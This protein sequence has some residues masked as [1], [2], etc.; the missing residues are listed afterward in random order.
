MVPR[1]AQ[2]SLRKGSLVPRGLWRAGRRGRAQCLA[3]ALAAAAGFHAHATVFVHR[4]V[5]RTLLGTDT[6]REG[7]QLDLLTDQ[8]GVRLLLPR[9]HPS[10]RRADVRAIEVET[11]A[12]CQCLRIGLAGARIRAGGAD[13]AQAKHSSM[14]CMR[15]LSSN[16]GACGLVF[17]I[18][19]I[20]CTDASW[21]LSQG[22]Q[23]L[24][25]STSDARP[26]P[27]ARR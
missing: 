18:C 16:A 23:R 25:R 15:A 21:L 3:R 26:S 22:W 8:L 5:L 12:A 11:N 1:P 17:V 10:R 9:Q 19:S 4:R 13:W 14:Q 6:T 20:T 2:S 7:A 27:G 24:S